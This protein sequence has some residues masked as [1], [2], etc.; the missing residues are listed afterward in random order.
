MREIFHAQQRRALER[1]IGVATRVRTRQTVATIAGDLNNHFKRA[2][3]FRNFRNI[4]R[5]IVGV[6]L[7]YRLRID[8]AAFFEFGFDTEIRTGAMRRRGQKKG[9]K[10]SFSVREVQ[11]AVSIR[12][13]LQAAPRV[14][15]ISQAPWF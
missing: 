3:R 9:E 12:P 7:F 10:N 2:R 13:V 1:L 8:G 6:F 11:E 5:C 4:R 14:A 15:H